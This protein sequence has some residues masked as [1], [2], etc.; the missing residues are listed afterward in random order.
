MNKEHGIKFEPTEGADENDAESV[1]QREQV[2]LYKRSKRKH[3]PDV[4]YPSSE[5]DLTILLTIEGL[6]QSFQEFQVHKHKDQCKEPMKEEMNS[7]LK[8][9]TYDLNELPKGKKALK[10]KWVFKLKQDGGKQSRKVVQL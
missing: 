3:R 1:D 8:N 2:T 6:Q 4:R 9:K 5:Y 10:K 7:L